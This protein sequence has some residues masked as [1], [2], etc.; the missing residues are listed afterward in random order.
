LQ[1]TQDAVVVSFKQQ[2]WTRED[3][4]D[5]WKKVYNTSAS[6]QWVCFVV[7]A[8]SFYPTE[9]WF[10]YSWNLCLTKH[11][12]ALGLMG[13]NAYSVVSQFEIIGEFG[14]FFGDFFINDEAIPLKLSYQ[15][16]YR[17][18]ENPDSQIGFA[19]FYGLALL[20]ESFTLFLLAAFGQVSSYI[21]TLLVERPHM[22]R[23]Y[24]DAVRGTSGAASALLQIVG[25]EVNKA[26]KIMSQLDLSPGPKAKPLKD[27]GD[28]KKN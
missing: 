28:K 20:S 18:L 1:S 24:G 5:S 16:I 3:A 19:G 10:A 4:F 22:K 9:C 21:F 14:W 27:S 26:K 17:F 15:G 6:M 25:E 12:V 7:A 2:G 11:I 13:L 8:V 23:K